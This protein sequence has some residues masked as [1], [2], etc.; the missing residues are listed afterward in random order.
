VETET[1]QQLTQIHEIIYFYV[2]L[3]LVGLHVAAN[4]AYRLLKGWD[5]ITPMITG[6]A[7]L[8][9]GAT[10]DLRFGLWG[11]FLICAGLSAALVWRITQVGGSSGF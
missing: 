7:P 6:S 9:E 3:A 4:V 10:A 1:A 8:P 11:R 2:I 5:L